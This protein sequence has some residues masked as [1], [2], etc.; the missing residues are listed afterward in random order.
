MVMTT[1]SLIQ[2]M[3]LSI[4]GPS[5]RLELLQVRLLPQLSNSDSGTINISHQALLN[6][7]SGL[8]IKLATTFTRGCKKQD[9]GAILQLYQQEAMQILVLY[10]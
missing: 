10:T 6:F 2:I 7:K 1:F 3:L 4:H 8:K 5:P 9:G